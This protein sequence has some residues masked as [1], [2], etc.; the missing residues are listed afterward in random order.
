MS[1]K[2]KEQVEVIR[3]QSMEAIKQAA[4]DLFA[5]KGYANTSVSAIAKVA[6]VSKGLMYNYYESKEKLLEAVIMD[7][8]TVGENMMHNVLD[9]RIPAKERLRLL[10]TGTFDW[11]LSHLPYYKLIVALSFQEDVMEELGD[12]AKQKAEAHTQLGELLFTQMG[13]EQPR[14]EA[15]QFGAIMD[16]IF[17]HFVHMEDDYPI[18]E[19]KEFLLKKYC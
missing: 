9:E 8:A 5:H 19:M 18:E 11:V 6:G 2:T 7:A 4:L 16:G 15:L 12:F 1:P 14:L 13:Y 10:L 3:Q 17:V